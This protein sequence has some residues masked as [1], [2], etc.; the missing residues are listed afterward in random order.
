L[1]SHIISRKMASRKMKM[2]KVNIPHPFV[3]SAA[4]PGE[5]HIPAPP[6]KNPLEV[7]GSGKQ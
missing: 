2:K 3:A 6:P 4:E 5:D 7:V 1:S